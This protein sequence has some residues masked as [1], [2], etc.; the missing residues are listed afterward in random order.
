MDVVYFYRAGIFVAK[1]KVHLGFQVQTSAKLI[2]PRKIGTTHL[3]PD[4]AQ[5]PLTKTC[6]NFSSK[7]LA[8]NA[9]K[10]GSSLATKIKMSK[11]VKLLNTEQICSI[12][13]DNLNLQKCISIFKRYYKCVRTSRNQQ[14]IKIPHCK[15]ANQAI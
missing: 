5:F 9:L 10:V 15:D 11:S 1:A 14:N 13:S 8:Q 7:K 6:K 12:F 3:S 4:L 2:S